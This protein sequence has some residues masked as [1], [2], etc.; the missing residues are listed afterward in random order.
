MPEPILDFVVMVQAG[1]HFRGCRYG[2]NRET[3]SGMEPAK[4]V[5]RTVSG[6]GRQRLFDRKDARAN[7]GRKPK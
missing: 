2:A 1:G 6:R 5:P 4:A 7:A 3:F